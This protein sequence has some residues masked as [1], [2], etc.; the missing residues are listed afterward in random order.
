[1]TGLAGANQ[2]AAHSLTDTLMS[3]QHQQ[4]YSIWSRTRLVLAIAIGLACG[5][6]GT[7]VAWDEIKGD[8]ADK[9]QRAEA[10]LAGLARP[11]RIDFQ[12]DP[13]PGFVLD[14]PS[15]RQA[16]IFNDLIPKA[17][18]DSSGPSAKY[19]PQSPQATITAAPSG[20]L[21]D[22][23]AIPVDWLEAQ[24][25]SAELTWPNNRTLEARAMIALNYSGNEYGW[26]GRY[27]DAATPFRV[28]S[29]AARVL[30][31]GGI[32]IGAAVGIFILA[33]PAMFLLSWLWY[34]MLSRIAEIIQALKGSAPTT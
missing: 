12:P 30:K 21:A 26:N 24:R 4:R 34:F 5:V 13:P 25:I 22:L 23:G 17:G 32:G 20:R 3:A 31:S 28:C 10:F 27:T 15:N 18:T 1:M 16:G 11:A 19:A 29:P 33:F 6:C 2:T 14:T 8:P 9:V 7:I